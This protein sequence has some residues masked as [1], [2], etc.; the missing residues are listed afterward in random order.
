MDLLLHSQVV[1]LWISEA[2][3]V[4]WKMGKV[5]PANQLRLV[6]YPPGNDH[7]SHLWK[8]KISGP[9]YLKMVSSQQVL[10][11][12]SLFT[13]GFSTIPGGWPWDF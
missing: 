4:S 6:V 11:G 2:S 7:I 5:H 12:I 8:R 10:E 13:T 9:C 1:G 3:T